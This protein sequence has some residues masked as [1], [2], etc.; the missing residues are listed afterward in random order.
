ML[1]KEA[2][3]ATAE[4]VQEA[5]AAW[6]EYWRIHVLNQPERTW[7]VQLTAPVTTPIAK[8]DKCL[9]LF[10]GR[11]LADK[12]VGSASVEVKSPPLYPKLAQT[13]FRLGTQ[14]QPVVLAFT[15]PED[16][17]AGKCGVSIHLGAQMQKVDITGLRLINYGPDF[18]EDKLP[19]PVL[20]YEGREADAPWRKEAFAR[21]E[22][23]RKGDFTLQVVDAK[24]TP[25]PNARVQATLRRHEFGFGSA[26]NA[27]WL[28][29]ASADG[30][31]YRAIVDECF[32]RVVFENDMKPFAWKEANAPGASGTYRRQWLE[33]SL[34]WLAERRFTVRGHYLCWGPFEEWSEALKSNPEAIREKV[35]AYIGE[36]LPA[37]GDRVAEWDALNHPVGWEKGMCIDTVLGFD[38]YVEVFKEARKLTKLPLW[39]N[40]D[41]V[42]REGR[43]QE[44]YFDVIQK[45]LKAGVRPDG[46]GNQAH[47]DSSYLPSPEEMLANSDRFARLVPALELTEFDVQTNG[48]EQ[49]AADFTRDILITTFSH[50]AY[51]GMVLWGFWEGAHWKPETALWRK[52]WS[53][54]PA[55]SAWKA[56]VCDQWRTKVALTTDDQGK[57]ALRGFFGSYDLTV[58]WDGASQTCP[59]LLGRGQQGKVKLVVRQKQ[60]AE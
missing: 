18:P 29:D 16:G 9:L 31:R 44:E 35:L 7:S 39:I 27:K 10:Y 43:Q 52:D 11:S 51:T 54:K 2:G 41:Q 12:A 56:L 20:T 60:E 24:G 37:M 53:E 38:F 57:A 5:G 36:I 4:R 8:G 23:H 40:E 42:F 34:T 19:R 26:V 49:L 46:I 25:V 14:W 47:F 28:N 48:D 59:V 1:P 6:P 55:V 17:P 58:E 32:S 21:I 30:E 15:A 50:P 13:N 45:L 33:Q 3:V 22:K